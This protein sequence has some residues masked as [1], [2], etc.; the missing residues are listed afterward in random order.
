M[1]GYLDQNGGHEDFLKDAFSLQKSFS[2]EKLVDGIAEA[3]TS[4]ESPRVVT[5]RVPV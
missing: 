4:S 1:T 5:R 2:R 3:L